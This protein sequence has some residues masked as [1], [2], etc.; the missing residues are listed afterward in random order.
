MSTRSRRRALRRHPELAET[1]RSPSASA[2]ANA[3]VTANKEALGAIGATILEVAT[4]GLVEV[5]PPS[6]EGE[7]V[8]ASRGAPAAG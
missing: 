4:L 5:P 3:A 6:R 7:N 2:S 1:N 8:P